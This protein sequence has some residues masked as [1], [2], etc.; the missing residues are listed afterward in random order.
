M[1]RKASTDSGASRDFDDIIGVSLLA[2]ALLLL[3]A[4]LSFDHKDISFLTTHVNKPTSN[5]IGPI[6]AYLAWLSFLPLGVAGYVLPELFLIFGLAYL[7][8]FLGH[9]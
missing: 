6:G 8:S 7:M 2:V 3:V 5:W 9:L 1:A 4:Q